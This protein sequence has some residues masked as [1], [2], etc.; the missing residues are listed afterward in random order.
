MSEIELFTSTGKLRPISDLAAEVEKLG[1]DAV[2]R[3][4][5]LKLAAE[6]VEAAEATAKVS[7]ENVR[8][9][10]RKLNDARENLQRAR[11]QRTFNQEWRDTLKGG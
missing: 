8:D 7:E 2:L 11:P 6:A 1:P 10:V 3:F 9:C 4:E 5:T